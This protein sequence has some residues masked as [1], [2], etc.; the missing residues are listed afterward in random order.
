[1]HSIACNELSL[2][3][4]RITVGYGEDDTFAVPQLQQHD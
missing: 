1:M 2:A 4:H 3:P